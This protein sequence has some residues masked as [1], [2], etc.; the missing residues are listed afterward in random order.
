MVKT[1][2]LHETRS[3]LSALVEEAVAGAE[4]VIAKN[5]RCH[6]PGDP[7]TWPW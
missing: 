6:H 4:T 7:V 5:G 3:S 2:N 1:P